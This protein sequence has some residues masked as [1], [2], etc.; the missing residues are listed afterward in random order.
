MMLILNLLTLR[1]SSVLMLLLPR[2]G[3]LEPDLRDPLAEARDLRDSLQVLPVGV[4]VQLEV[5]LQHLQLLLREGGAHALRLALVVALALAAV[6][7]GTLC[8]INRLL[9]RIVLTHYT[10]WDHFHLLDQ[11]L[12]TV[13]L[14]CEGSPQVQEFQILDSGTLDRFE[15]LNRFEIG[16][17][18]FL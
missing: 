14:F 16:I 8:H 12:I 7:S 10:I 17:G 18:S 11:I 5:G 9:Q 13:H 3:V 2:P 15:T 4:R 1:F 6:W